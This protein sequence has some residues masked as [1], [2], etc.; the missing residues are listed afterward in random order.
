MEKPFLRRFA[1]KIFIA[2]NS[3]IAILF[4]AGAFA[5]YFSPDHWWFFGL[6]TFILA[7]LLLALV[8]FLVFWLFKKSFFCCISLI[9]IISGWHAVI[10]IFPLNFSSSFSIQKKT[11]NIRVMSWNVEQFNILH[12]KDHPEVK[13]EM[14]D[15]INK[16]DP[17]IACF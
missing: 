11:G 10:N 15:L 3:I 4:L 12:H 17:D 6:F 9:T 13:Q 8:F 1:K 2:L 7:Y 16:Y 5:K 14:L